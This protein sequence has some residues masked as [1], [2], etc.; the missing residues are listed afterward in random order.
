M[1]T[2]PTSQI[3]LNVLQGL[4]RGGVI[5]CSYKK[6]IITIYKGITEKIYGWH[7]VIILCMDIHMGCLPLYELSAH[8]FYLAKLEGEFLIICK[9]KHKKIH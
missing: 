8:N 7:S 3:G 9:I 5:S 1:S 6:F 2:P 4:V